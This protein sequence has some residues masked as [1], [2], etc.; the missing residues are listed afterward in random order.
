MVSLVLI[1]NGFLN[2]SVIRVLSIFLLLILINPPMPCVKWLSPLDL[3]LN[4]LSLGG[5][6]TELL[7][8][9]NP[10]LVSL[11][12]YFFLLLLLCFLVFPLSF[13]SFLF[14]SS[15]NLFFFFSFLL[16]SHDKI[17]P[18]VLYLDF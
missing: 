9:H 8:N 4:L 11:F 14:F 7:S 15:V 1:L 13:L 6:S 17:C 3:P 18:V 2:H 10:T 5:M 16:A 12:L